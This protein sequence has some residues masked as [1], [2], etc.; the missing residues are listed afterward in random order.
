[1]RE[2]GQPQKRRK[3][4]VHPDRRQHRPRKIKLLDHTWTPAD[5]GP[6]MYEISWPQRRWIN[7]AHITHWY[8]LAKRNG[9]LLAAD[10]ACT[11]V[12]DMAQALD[13]AGCLRLTGDSK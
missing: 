2:T 13:R 11:V 10:R 1:M 12:H 3:W 4:R 7:L 8:E 5:L 6:G 9:D